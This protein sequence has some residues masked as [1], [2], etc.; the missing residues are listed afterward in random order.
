M[1]RNK[2]EKPAWAIAQLIRMSGLLED[3]C[4]HGVGHPNQA[5]LDANK[6]MFDK[7]Y[8]IHDCDGCCSK[9]KVYIKTKQ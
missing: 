1:T 2:Y 9:G 4:E 7:G 5:F 6:E 3:I 8:S